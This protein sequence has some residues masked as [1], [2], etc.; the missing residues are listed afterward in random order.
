MSSP[1]LVRRAIQAKAQ[2]ARIEQDKYR[3]FLRLA[4][5]VGVVA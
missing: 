5:L 4:N 2:K 3:R 1:G